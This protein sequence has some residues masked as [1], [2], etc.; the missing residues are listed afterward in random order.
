MK[1]LIAIPA[2]YASTRL[3][4]KPLISIAG[5]TLIERVYRQCEKVKGVSSVVV[6]TDHEGIFDE[7]VSFGGVAMMTKRSHRSG[8]E[9]VAEVARKNRAELVIN[10]Q[11]DEPLLEPRAIQILVDGMK[12]DSQIGI[13]TLANPITDKSDFLDPNVVKV[14][15]DSNNWALYFSR[16][17]IP[18]P[19][20]NPKSVPN[21]AYRHVGIYGYLNDCLQRW[22]R[23]PPTRLEKLE[24]LEQLRALEN[25]FKIKVFLTKYEAIGVDVASDVKKVERI[26]A[27]R[28]RAR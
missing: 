6:A 18:Y 4:G 11:G 25:G 27:K 2:R 26:L 23:L 15:L 21:P 20:D 28:S 5:T 3:P 12:R 22:V 1:T 14:V 24:K 7:V 10:V 19:R 13:G 16:A 9:R 17:S 8:S